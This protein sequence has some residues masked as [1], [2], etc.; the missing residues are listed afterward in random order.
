MVSGSQ[1]ACWIPTGYIGSARVSRWAGWSVGEADFP[2]AVIVKGRVYWPRSFVTTKP[3]HDLSFCVI[4][5]YEPAISTQQST[6]APMYKVAS[7][8]SS[9]SPGFQGQLQ[10]DIIFGNIIITGIIGRKP[11]DDNTCGSIAIGRLNCNIMCWHC[12]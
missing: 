4:I 10:P 5:C 11:I 7:F 9:T 12:N 6:T 8:R 2:G 1:K 3:H